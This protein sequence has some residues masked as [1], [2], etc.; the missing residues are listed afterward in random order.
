M[1]SETKYQTTADRVVAHPSARS[2]PQPDLGDPRLYLNREL[3]WLNFNERVLDQARGEKHPLLERVKFL[4]IAANNLDEFFMIRVATLTRQLRAGLPAISPDGMTLAEQLAAVRPRAERMLE[5]IARCWEDTLRPLMAAAGVHFLD[6]EDYPPKVRAYLASYFSANVCPVLTPLAFDPGH[7]FPYISNRSKSLAV[8]VDDGGQTKFARV[9]VPDVLPRFVPI[10]PPHADGPGQCYAFLE[11]VIEQNLSELFAGVAL[12]SAHLFRI[13]RDTDIVLREEEAEDL[14]ESVDRSLK[15]M[16]HGPITLLQTGAGTPDRVLNILIENFELHEP[17]VVPTGARIGLAD[18]IALT[19]LPRPELKDVPAIPRTI[20]RNLEPEALFDSIKYR[21]Q[22][23]HHPF[24]S[25]SAVEAFLDAAVEDPH[26]AAIKLTLYRIG[27][28]SPIVDR[29]IQAAERGKQVAV[30]VELKARFDERS[31]IE[32]ATRLED[33]GVHVVYGLVNLK[34]HCKLCL[35]VRK[36]GDRVQRYLHIGTGNYNRAT[37]QIYTDLGLFTANEEIV[38]DASEL[39]NHLTGYSHQ[40][41]YRA[42]L[43][44]P[45]ALRARLTALVERE[46]DHSRAGRHCGIIIKNNSVSDPDVVRL[47]YRAS[48]AGVRVDAIV[49]GICCLKPGLAGISDLIRVR[50]IVGR[51]LEHSRIYCFENGGEPDIYIGSADL[52]ERNLDRR[53][54][55]LCPVFDPEIRRYLREELLKTYLRDDTRASLLKPDGRYEPVLDARPGTIDAQ[56]VLLSRRT[57]GT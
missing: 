24:D 6:P 27:G 55:T 25:F 41:E 36:E 3:S 44:A 28:N 11:D 39:F 10:P 35:V 33:A 5:D 50:S 57:P 30:L 8:V 16:R 1:A 13:L 23:V 48:A 21:D 7:P 29:L 56:H 19:R 47:L 22:L 32:W 53:V 52:M 43:V 54:E 40:T 9:K 20:W 18:W 34:T 37:S 46:I 2:N 4:A 14:L 31:N 15:A 17:V 38:A 49:R 51:F 45:V 12:R 26:V 42:L